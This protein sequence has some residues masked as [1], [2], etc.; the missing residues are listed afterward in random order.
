M[1]AEARARAM[2]VAGRI[3][4]PR[5]VL[6]GGEQ[7][8]LAAAQPAPRIGGRL[9]PSPKSSADCADSERAANES[10]SE[11]A[12][13]SYGSPPPKREIRLVPEGQA[14]R[15]RST[16]DSGEVECQGDSS[17][18]GHMGIAGAVTDGGGRRIDAGRGWPRPAAASRSF[19]LEWA[20]PPGT[21]TW[22]RGGRCFLPGFLRAAPRR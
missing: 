3:A 7:C 17:L 22:L 11:G 20:P 14:S 5:A 16:G 10:E 9:F 12:G 18:R 4:R 8:Q 13:C 2:F 1:G 19:R 21:S 6:R 15:D